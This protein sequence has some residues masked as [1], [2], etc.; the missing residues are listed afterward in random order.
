MHDFQDIADRVEIEAL[1]A[2]G[3]GPAR[4]RRGRASVITLGC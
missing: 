2:G 3:R 1:R 4:G